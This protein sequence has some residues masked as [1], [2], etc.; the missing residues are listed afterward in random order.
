MV[1]ASITAVVASITAASI[2]AVTTVASIMAD[3]MA[4][5]TSGMAE[6]ITMAGGMVIAVMAAG[7]PVTAIT[8]LP[9]AGAGMVRARGIGKHAVAS[10][11]DRCGSAR[12]R[13]SSNAERPR[14]YRGFFLCDGSCSEPFRL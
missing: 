1:A 13:K 3:A 12:N 11:S 7:L 9:E 10:W 8:L 14:Q 2:T 5:A 4:G 6:D